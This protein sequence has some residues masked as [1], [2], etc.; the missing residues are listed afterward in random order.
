MQSMQ[1]PPG[2][3]ACLLCHQA[4][5]S[6][7]PSMHAGLFAVR[8]IRQELHNAVMRRPIPRAVNRQQIATTRA[9]LFRMQSRLPRWRDAQPVNAAR[10]ST[11]RR[12]HAAT[13]PCNAR[14]AMQIRPES[15]CAGFAESPYIHHARRSTR[16]VHGH[17][18]RFSGVSINRRPCSARPAR[19]PARD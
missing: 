13:D 15:R 3:R 18:K 2:I 9:G 16:A 7:R 10:S 17:F 5:K 8:S 1:P 11:T 12:N 19:P 14:R 4:G 6:C